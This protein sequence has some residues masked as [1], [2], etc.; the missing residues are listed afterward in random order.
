MSAVG[1]AVVVFAAAL[2]HSESVRFSSMSAGATR[3][4]STEGGAART[5]SPARVDGIAIAVGMLAAAAVVAVARAQG[6]PLWLVLLC[7]APGFSYG[8]LVSSWVRL[9]F[10]AYSVWKTLFSMFRRKGQRKS[11]GDALHLHSVVHCR[12]VRPVTCEGARRHCWARNAL[13]PRLIW[14][15]PALC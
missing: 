12:V 2:R 13:A 7:A 11:T 15:L 10:L 5:R 14:I 6:I 8:L 9:V 1:L 4:C 3:A